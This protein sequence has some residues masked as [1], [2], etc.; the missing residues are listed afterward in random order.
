MIPQPAKSQGL[1][2]RRAFLG[3]LDESMEQEQLSVKGSKNG[4]A[5]TVGKTG[6]DFRQTVAK[7][8][9]QWPANGP[10]AL[11]CLDVIT[12]DLLLL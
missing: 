3:F 10:A 1:F 2:L 6:S 8:I 5:N 11:D 12:D 4:A 9:H 7:A